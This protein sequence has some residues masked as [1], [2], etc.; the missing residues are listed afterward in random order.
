V[1]PAALITFACG[2]TGVHP[3]HLRVL[4]WSLVGSNVIALAALVVA[5]R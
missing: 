5:L 2:F 3:R 4:G 1:L